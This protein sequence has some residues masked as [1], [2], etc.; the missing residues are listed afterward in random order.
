M[1]TATT[2]ELLTYLADLIETVERFGAVVLP[3]HDA[4]DVDW[5]RQ[6]DDLI[7]DLATRLP[8][9]PRAHSV[10]LVLQER[11]G[12]TVGGRWVLAEYGYEV[13]HH[14][15]DYRRA[16]HRHD[17]D[18]FVRVFGVATHEHCE[19]SLGHGTCGHYAGEPV[20]GAIDGFR[21]LYEV[22]L[23][24]SKPDCSRLRCLG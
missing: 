10:D 13:R 12:P 19:T 4:D 11:W 17:V 1:I 18:Y 23:T 22:W 20:R 21:R 5:A 16:L 14:G 24:G 7:L 9:A 2:D 6:G 15:L 3:P 8:A